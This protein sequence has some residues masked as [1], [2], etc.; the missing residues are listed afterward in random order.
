MSL[1]EQILEARDIQEELVE[2]PEWGV[3]ILVRGLTGRQRAQ[4]LQNA[5]D[6]AGRVD[7]ARV[8]PELVIYCVYDP[9]TKEQVFKP[10]DRDMLL[11]KSGTVLERIATTAMRLSGLTQ[12]ALE[13]M[14]RNF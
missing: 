13:E 9:E 1:R 11:E 10:A 2:V 4:L 6:V 8:L 3:K 7:L 5:I 14:K 12:E